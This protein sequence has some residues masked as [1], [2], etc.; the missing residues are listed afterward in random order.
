MC[1]VNFHY[2]PGPSPYYSQTNTITFSRTGS[3]TE[4]LY[5][6]AA[7]LQQNAKYQHT[8]EYLG[9]SKKHVVYTDFSVGSTKP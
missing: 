5:D 2:L 4:T 7:S 1:S 8:Y 9:F 3:I 6:D